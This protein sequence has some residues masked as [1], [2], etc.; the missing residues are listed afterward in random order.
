MGT[1]L[2]I[3]LCSYFSYSFNFF[4][5]GVSCAAVPF[6]RWSCLS[7]PLAFQGAI[8]ADKRPCI[9]KSRVMFKRPWALIQDSTV[10]AMLQKWERNVHT[11]G[12]QAGVQTSLQHYYYC[13]CYVN[14]VG[15]IKCLH[16][17]VLTSS[18]PSPRDHYLLA[19]LL[20]F[21]PI[22]RSTQLDNRQK[23][24]ACPSKWSKGPTNWLAI[25]A[26]H[27]ENLNLCS[28]LDVYHVAMKW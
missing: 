20:P 23:P 3:I 11:I 2:L 10:H 25:M 21:S 18:I 26:T 5:S 4:I 24:M 28:A 17:R 14:F 7:V 9:P 1:P 19:T 27:F 13:G 22:W 12:V 6:R 8:V 16:S 15:S